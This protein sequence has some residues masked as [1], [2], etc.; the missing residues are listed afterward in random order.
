[1]A[2]K[3]RNKIMAEIAPNYV[4]EFNCLGSDCIDTCCQ[5]CQCAICTAVSSCNK[6]QEENNRKP[7]TELGLGSYDWEEFIA[8]RI[9]TICYR[10]ASQ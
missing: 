5:G 7:K 1:M 2:Y 6:A 3:L 4:N 8:L 10:I 9:N